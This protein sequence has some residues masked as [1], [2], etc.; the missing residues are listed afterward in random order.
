MKQ[1]KKRQL[2]SQV[3]PNSA[4]WGQFLGPRPGLVLLLPAGQD[5]V[6]HPHP[7]P[8]PCPICAPPLSPTPVP[9]PFPCGAA[10]RRQI[11]DTGPLRKI[12]GRPA[13]SAPTKGFSGRPA[14]RG[15]GG[16]EPLGSP[17]PLRPSLCT[18]G[19]SRLA[20]QRP[21]RATATCPRGQGWGQG[22]RRSSCPRAGAEEDFGRPGEEEHRGED[23][24]ATQLV[25][26]SPRLTIKQ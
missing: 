7:C 12:Y 14:G 18:E 11:D 22:R 9:G 10:T 26:F 2:F 8:C 17:V 16:E 3:I 23:Y 6:P 13:R 5:E 4:E 25:P 20:F 19:M 21:P 1:T 15:H 24:P